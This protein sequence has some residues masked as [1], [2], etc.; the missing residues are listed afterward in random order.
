MD[1]QKERGPRPTALCSSALPRPPWSGAMPGPA[2][3]TRAAAPRP[4]RPPVSHR[5][6]LTISF[7]RS[8]PLQNR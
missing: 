3:S 7:R 6:Y 5:M 2:S 1:R 8:T 4:E